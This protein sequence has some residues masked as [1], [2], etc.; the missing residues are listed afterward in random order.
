MG[1]GQ[2][3]SIGQVRTSC[4]SESSS[5]SNSVT[6]PM[7][8]E[9]KWIGLFEDSK[10]IGGYGSTGGG[11]GKGSGA[12]M[13]SLDRYIFHIAQLIIQL[14]L[15]VDYLEE[16]K[17]SS[18]WHLKSSGHVNNSLNSGCGDY[19]NRNCSTRRYWGEEW[20]ESV[21]GNCEDCS[22][23]RGNEPPHCYQQYRGGGNQNRNGS[24]WRMRGAAGIGGTATASSRQVLKLHRHY[25][26]ADN[27]HQRCSSPTEHDQGSVEEEV[28]VEVDVLW[29]NGLPIG[30][31]LYMAEDQFNMLVRSRQGSSSSSP[32]VER[33]SSNENITINE[34]QDKDNPRDDNDVVSDDDNS[35]SNRYA[36]LPRFGGS[37][38]FESW[39]IR[40]ETESS[41]VRKYET[42]LLD[43]RRGQAFAALLC[44]LERYIHCTEIQRRNLFDENGNS[45]E[46]AFEY[47]IVAAGTSPLCPSPVVG[48]RECGDMASSILDHSYETSSFAALQTPF[49]R[50]H[51]EVSTCT[52]ALGKGIKQLLKDNLLSFGEREEDYQHPCAK[53]ESYQETCGRLLKFNKT[54]GL[55]LYSSPE[56]RQCEKLNVRE[57]LSEEEATLDAALKLKSSPERLCGILDERCLAREEGNIN[58]LEPEEE[59]SYFSSPERKPSDSPKASSRSPG[60]SR[61]PKSGSAKR[62]SS[63]KSHALASLFKHKSY[64]QSKPAVGLRRAMT[65]DFQESLISGRMAIEHTGTVEGFSMRIG[66]LGNKK[67]SPHIQIPFTA[68]FYEFQ[69]SD[70]PVPYCG[71]VNINDADQSN[72]GLYR[73]PLKGHVQI[74]VANPHKTAVKVYLVKY[75]YRE[76][77]ENTK[78][79][80]RQKTIAVRNNTLIY[81]C[82]LKF[83]C[84][85]KG[86]LYIY[87]N[88]RAVFS[89][90][91]PDSIDECRVEYQNPSNPEFFPC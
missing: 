36:S 58:N 31:N 54:E 79:I 42:N 8:K 78:T 1:G 71:E 59:I 20:G 11:G 27:L 60:A 88:V 55:P 44:D 38:L 74:V 82:Q 18:D 9:K 24:Y 86:K 57:N 47:R 51:V 15:G 30:I 26:S 6:M 25:Q 34:N 62:K 2:G 81:A 7:V 73:V 19:N 84:S 28:N 29:K 46:C 70:A 91:F 32:M 22:S 10:S 66:S 21:E 52:A 48:L 14:R 56:S 75:D 23:D 80:L 33:R 69:A 77:P 3:E 13:S 40:Y 4:G 49:G 41:P 63:S 89:H 53:G 90:R 43:I 65:V 64:L 76:M 5:S 67:T 85:P 61:N 72:K 12:L 17:G 37:V 87:D 45:V 39:V 50:L 35:F 68:K 83:W 16:G